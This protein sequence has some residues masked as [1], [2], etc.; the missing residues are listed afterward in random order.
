M[1]GSSSHPILKSEMAGRDMVTD[2]EPFVSE[3]PK[4][5]TEMLENRTDN[6]SVM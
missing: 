1:Q 6:G 4:D 5:L 3:T 2:P